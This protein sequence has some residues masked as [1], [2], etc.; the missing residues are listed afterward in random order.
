MAG[1]VTEKLVPA[2][3]QDYFK[4]TRS[5]FFGLLSISLLL[6]IYEGSIATLYEN[7]QIEVRNSAEIMIKRMLWFFGLRENV[8]LWAAFLLLLGWAY[9]LA[10][11]QQLLKL[12]FVYLPY[13]IFESTLYAMI[14]GLVVGELTQRFS[15]MALLQSNG[16]ET[17]MNVKMTLAVGAGVYEEL[18]FRFLLLSLLLL[19]F[20]K[21]A[22]GKRLFNVILSVVIS[23]LLFSGFHYLGGR[24]LFTFE[25][26]MFRF[27]AGI[28]L[29]GLFVARGIGTTSY[30]HALYNLLL[31]FR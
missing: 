2:T 13:I 23:A 25:S 29:G 4:Y 21:L 6:L 31:L 3:L 9:W 20:E 8:L 27:Y 22:G 12:K 30:T 19:I 11:K 18:L 26:F 24:E 16:P 10:K 17:D 7:Q 28:I 1:M 15:L 5:H 14:F